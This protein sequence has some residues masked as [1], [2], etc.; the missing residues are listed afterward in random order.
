M[1][2]M[3]KISLLAFVVLFSINLKAQTI[4]SWKITDLTKYINHSDSVL[5]INFWATFCKPCVAEIPYFQTI[6]DKY[7]GQKVKLILV[8]LDLKEAFPNKIAAFAASHSFHNKIVW[9]NET[10]ADYF[11]PRVD[12]KWSGVIPTTLFVNLKTGYR[13]LIEDDIPE[14]QFETELKKA[15]Q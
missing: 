14:K 12:K 9:L 10:N 1:F 7:K 11:C 3:K 4:E 8:S 5:V 15:I 2:S 6:V 13:K